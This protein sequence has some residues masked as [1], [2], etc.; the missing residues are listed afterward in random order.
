MYSEILVTFIRAIITYALALILTILMG[1]KLISQMT[2]FDFV[3]GV[4]MGSMAANLSIGSKNTI[5]SSLT[6]LITF[7]LLT[8]LIGYIHIKNFKV[9]KIINS[10]PVVL[11]SYGN[12]VEHNMKRVRIT[13]EQ[14]TMLL[15][16]KNFF[17]LAD[18]EFAILESNGKLSV[19]P[20]A[21]KAPLTPSH[22]N[23]PT[24]SK[25]LMRD[26]VIDGNLMKENLS[27][28]GIDIQW[29]NSQ[30]NMNGIKNISDI[31]YAGIDNAKNLYFSKKN[32]ENEE[33]N[34]KYGIE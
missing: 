8:I 14:L 34:N 11:I 6:S 26:I 25:G 21:D 20:K 32:N 15:R 17:S 12:I 4:S 22:M 1:R 2:F 7:A 10:E 13:I 9:R 23:I 31:F 30:L 16:E 27:F 24:V 5:T 19:L 18:V 28:A 29:L 33:I 3:V